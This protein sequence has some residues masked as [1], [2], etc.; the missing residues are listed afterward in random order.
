M[1]RTKVEK[2]GSLLKNQ[3]EQN[4]VVE[5]KMAELSVEKFWAEVIGVTI[6]SFTQ[7][8]SVSEGVLYLKL[9]SPL[10]KNEVMMMRAKIIDH[11]NRYAGMPIVNRIV[12]R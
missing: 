8:V 9:S 12:F 2:L 11:I 4:E 1:K 10:V 5:K 6:A 7:E 3:A